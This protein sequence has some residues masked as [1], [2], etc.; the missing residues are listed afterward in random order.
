M[1]LGKTFEGL[2]MWAKGGI[3]VGV[4]A[5]SAIVG[6]AIYN[7]VKGAMALGKEKKGGKE[8]DKEIEEL[9]NSGAKPPTISKAQLSIMSDQLKTAFDGPSFS[10]DA[11]KV[12]DILSQPKNDADVLMLIRA[13][14]IR[15][16]DNAVYGTFKGTLPQAIAA[17]IPQSSLY[18]K[19]INDI[20][21]MFGKK[22]IKTRF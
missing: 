8:I 13:Y 21:E 7:K 9:K 10:G 18:R 12:F 3:A 16:Y 17:E 4:L 2:P 6:F 5:L 11:Q 19:S 20:N 1:D 22:N 14:G 15:S